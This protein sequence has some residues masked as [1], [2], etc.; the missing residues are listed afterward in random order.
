MSI[1]LVNCLYLVKRKDRCLMLQQRK[2]ILIAIVGIVRYIF[3]VPTRCKLWAI[4]ANKG[5]TEVSLLPSAL[6]W[7]HP[8]IML[9]I[10]DTKIRTNLK[11]RKFSMKKLI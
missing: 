9:A 8:S 6:N 2:F 4:Q 10:Q 5:K 7:F 3:I 11:I 1:V